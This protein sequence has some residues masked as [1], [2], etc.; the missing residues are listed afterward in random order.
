MTPTGSTREI[1][2]SPTK[3]FFIRILVKDV[4]LI[5]AILDL[6]DNSIDSHIKNNLHE[7]KLISISLSENEFVIEDNCGGIDKE[8]IYER[9]FRF[10]KTSEEHAKTIG[11]YGI[12]LKRSI[13]KLGKNI[14]IESDDGTNYYSI[15]IK[16]DWLDNED[17]WNLTFDKEEGSSGNPFTRVTITN[18]YPNIADELKTIELENN[19]KN[20]IRD[21]YSIFMKERVTI[22]V[23]KEAVDYYEFEFLCE[24][25][26]FAPFHETH[27]F[28]DVEVEIFAGYSP[29]GRGGTSSGWY[30]FC[31]DRLI[32]SQ[33]KSYR[34]GWGD[35][36]RK[37]HYPED[38]W[39]L[40]LVFFRSDDPMSLPWQTTKDDIQYDS[41]VYRGAQI[42]MK[43]I[44]KR[45]TDVI[46]KA[47]RTKDAAGET[48]G[49]T[50][51]LNVPVIP[52][53]KIED[54]QKE[55]VPALKGKDGV[56]SINIPIMT[57]IQYAKKN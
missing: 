57:N 35:S 42:E 52:L 41:R 27:Q 45:L 13:F 30:V 14:L 15:P 49:T 1:N 54:E 2:A 12:G 55:T 10:G 25:G 26:K 32:I 51:F 17:D 40:G 20:R 3:S 44:T 39:F 36:D 47:G 23:N 24:E 9:V 46:R 29:G 22:E 56:V 43:S 37:Y 4:D 19:L 16:E 8:E 38:D 5:D 18:L 53:S 6:I 33:D 50:L 31:N 11:I 7:K 28:G 21:T 48:I 34:T